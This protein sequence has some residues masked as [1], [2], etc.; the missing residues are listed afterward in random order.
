MFSL[1]VLLL[2]LQLPSVVLC[3]PVL[4]MIPSNRSA[5]AMI[6]FMVSVWFNIP[7]KL[8]VHSIQ[9]LLLVGLS[10]I[11]SSGRAALMSSRSQTTLAIRAGFPPEFWCTFCHFRNRSS[12]LIE[13]SK[14]CFHLWMNSS[15][16]G[17]CTLSFMN[18]RKAPSALPSVRP[19]YQ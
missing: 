7:A 12:V 15:S 6:S 3:T 8:C 14:G 18:V 16:V 5:S 11:A 13:D 4:Y 1:C 17:G 10:L 9:K 2:E 19:V